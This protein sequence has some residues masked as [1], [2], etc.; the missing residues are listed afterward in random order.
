M[1]ALAGCFPNS[2]S[3]PFSKNFPLCPT[4]ANQFDQ[5]APTDLARP[6]LDGT[7]S[8]APKS[9][10]RE[11]IQADLSFQ[12]WPANWYVSRVPPRQ[13]G[14]SRSSRNVGRDAMDVEVPL[15]SG[16]EADGKIVWS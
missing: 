2:L 16:A 13:E 11:Q 14:R 6:A 9:Q 15:T 5:F 10:F 12:S 7:K 3:S 4:G 1:D 8:R